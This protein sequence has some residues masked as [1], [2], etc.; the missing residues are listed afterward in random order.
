[1]TL[2]MPDAMERGWRSSDLVVGHAV[3]YYTIDGKPRCDVLAP[4][5]GISAKACEVFMGGLRRIRAPRTWNPDSLDF[6]KCP[7]VLMARQ[8]DD[9]PWLVIAAKYTPDTP[10][11]EHEVDSEQVDTTPALS[12]ET[13]SD[14]GG[15]RT[16]QR[17]NGDFVIESVGNVLF[18][19]S[20]GSLQIGGNNA[21]DNAAL[22]SSTI[23][24]TQ[25][26]RSRVDALELKLNETALKLTALAETLLM[27][28]ASVPFTVTP[29]SLGPYLQD[30]DDIRCELI[31]VAS[32]AP[33]DL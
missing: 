28:P 21:K 6:K 33:D 3:A 8:P 17:S 30:L 16:F 18:K 5:Y 19:F 11:D 22:A 29:V 12:D 1:M 13:L 4:E 2:T 15:T 10:D 31:R 14:N 24:V 20:G 9:L 32:G 26:L 7:I 27:H 25:D 23:E